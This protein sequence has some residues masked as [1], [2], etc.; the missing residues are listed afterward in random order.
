MRL[1]SSVVAVAAVLFVACGSD[2]AAPPPLGAA[3]T[4]GSAGA[5]SG[6][7][8]V[9]VFS[10]TA[11]YHH[12]SI[13]DGQ[14]ALAN[15][16]ASSGWT[17]TTTDDA[18]VFTDGGLEALDVVVFLSTT[19]DVLDADQQAAFERFIGAGKGF[20]GIHSASDT[21]YDWPF[22]G[23]LVG[24][25]FREHPA[26]Q[27]ADL[28]LEDPNDPTTAG[29]PTTW[30]RT[31]EWY[32]FS[33]NPRPNVHVLLTLDESSYSPGT[34]TMGADHPVTWLHE[35]AGGRAFYTAL[36]HTKQSYDEPLFIGMLTRAI[37]W[38]GGRVS[39]PR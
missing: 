17:L 12:D 3:G 15:V 35:Y 39:D 21:E 16:A 30:T 29:L 18:A 34:A 26:I 24:A 38:A 27:A 22:Y 19:G 25:Y 6:P 13:P 32:A 4:T 14:A 2:P 33:E 36:G 23:E 7:L 37:E 11:G 8:A 28:K 10:K 9:L 31:D 5:P 1:S 20:V